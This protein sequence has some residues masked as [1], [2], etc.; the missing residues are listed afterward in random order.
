MCLSLNK[1]G[2]LNLEHLKDSMSEKVKAVVISHISNVIGSINPIKEISDIVHKY[3][4]VVIVD[5]AQS[6]PHIKIDV[7]DL[8]CDVFAFSAHKMCGPTGLGI[9][10]GKMDVLNKTQPLIVGG[11]NNVNYFSDGQ[12]FLKNAPYKFESGTLPLAQII[13]FDTSLTYL[14]KIGINIISEY[15]IE[16]KDYLISRLK[17]LKNIKIYNPEANTGLLTFNI[18]GVYGADAGK[19]FNANGIAVRTGQ[20]CTRL[21]I[22]EFQTDSTIRVSLYFYNTFE[23]IDKF[24]EVCR[25][26]TRDNIYNLIFN[27]S[28][29]NKN[30]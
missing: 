14:E 1:N 24:I 18:K 28:K 6:A 23:E 29:E 13:A 21:L 22:D 12:Y 30:V 15:E 16:L 2:T 9:L 4:A 11:G 26:A 7:R 27:N 3:S 10:Y 8:D 17:I 19:W 20:H 5:G 25:R